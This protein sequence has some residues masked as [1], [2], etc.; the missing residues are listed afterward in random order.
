MALSKKDRKILEVHPE[1]D[2]H[3]ELLATVKP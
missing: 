3:A 1:T 2:L